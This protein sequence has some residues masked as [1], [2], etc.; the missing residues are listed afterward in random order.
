MTLQ[1]QSSKGLR[2]KYWHMLA[3]GPAKTGKSTFCG[4]MPNVL[5]V[6]MDEGGMKSLGHK[7]IQFVEPASWQ[8]LLSVLS[9]IQ[10]T[11]KEG[12]FRFGAQEFQ[13]VAFDPLNMLH[14]F[15]QAS[16]LAMKRDRQQLSLPDHGLANDKTMRF[17][18]DAFKLETHV[19]FTCLERLEKDEHTGRVK[20]GPDLTPAL[21]RDVP[22]KP[23]YIFHTC[24]DPAGGGKI[25]FTLA[26]QNEGYYEA[27]GRY[28]DTPLDLREEP[29][30]M[31][32][33]AKV[34]KT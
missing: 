7:D 13:S 11:C 6:S 20:A 16:V 5:V 34:N 19:L 1:T 27:G 18:V 12:K 10:S 21:M 4:T 33:Y 14:N 8:D 9:T 3:Y 29:D 25:K 2:A 31:K 30:F 15:S 17:I 22:A 23:D 28:A 24:A 26:T 32:L